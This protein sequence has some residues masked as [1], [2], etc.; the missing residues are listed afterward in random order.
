M[1]V[2]LKFL[3]ICQSSYTLGYMKLHGPIEPVGHGLAM[4]C[5]RLGIKYLG[6]LYTESGQT[7]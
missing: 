3:G 2:K 1:M 7:F 5:R 4:F 6:D